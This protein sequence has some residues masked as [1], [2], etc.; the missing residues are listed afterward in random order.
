MAPNISPL[1]HAVTAKPLPK[2]CLS[3]ERD[4]GAVNI[5]VGK[6]GGKQ[7]EQRRAR[8][9]ISVLACAAAG[10]REGGGRASRH[11]P[12]GAGGHSSRL[13]RSRYPFTGSYAA[14]LHCLFYLRLRLLA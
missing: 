1:Q 6:A 4:I 2:L 12:D 7:N 13:R 10:E 14:P 11:Q 5:M 3:S 8:A 9:R